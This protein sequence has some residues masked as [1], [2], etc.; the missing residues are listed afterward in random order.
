MSVSPA[1]ATISA[2]AYGITSID[3]WNPGSTLIGT[4]R[5]PCCP[6]GVHSCFFSRCRGGET[7]FWV[8]VCL[9]KA[10]S[11]TCRVL[12]LRNWLC[13]FVPVAEEPLRYTAR[14]RA[15]SHFQVLE[16]AVLFPLLMLSCSSVLLFA[17]HHLPTS[18]AR[19]V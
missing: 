4:G 6:H 16:G 9:S 2:D 1:G 17:Q 8:F 13:L 15:R 18:T 14:I 12:R 19:M 11:T 5:F 3:G 7:D 10:R